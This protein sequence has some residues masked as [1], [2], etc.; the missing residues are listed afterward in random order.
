MVFETGDKIGRMRVVE[1][2]RR[3]YVCRC[4]KCRQTSEVSARA[5]RLKREDVNCLKCYP[6]LR[7]PR[8][9]VFRTLKGFPTVNDMRDAA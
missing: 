2:A 9:E 7:Q 8:L 6:R 4:T 1:R 3:G 5:L